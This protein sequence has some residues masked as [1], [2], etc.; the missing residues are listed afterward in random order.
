MV[1]LARRIRDREQLV[2]LFAYLVLGWGL[3]G[4]ALQTGRSLLG[5]SPLEYT[6]VTHFYFT[7]QS[8]L[9]VVI[10]MFIFLFKKKRGSIFTSFAYITL[11]NISMT[12]IIFHALLTPYMSH[13]SFLNHVLHT[14]TPLLYVCFYFFVIKE[15]VLISKFW[16]SLLYPLLY[17]LAVYIIIEP[18]FGDMMERLFTTFE[19]PRYV[20][21]F[22]S[23]RSY[24]TGV[25]GLILFNLGILAPL[26]ALYSFLL[27]YLKSRFEKQLNGSN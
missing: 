6:L 5:S 26:V 7:T 8:N 20:Y 1:K 2:K 11:I 4:V 9:L 13:V 21:P 24:T 25:R 12:G 23:P 16:L 22:L 3:V 14:I 15:H 10:M 17:M 18:L 19:D 27:C